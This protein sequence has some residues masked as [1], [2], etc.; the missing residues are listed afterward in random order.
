MMNHPAGLR[1]KIVPSPIGQINETSHNLVKE[2]W[3]E[4]GCLIARVEWN[5]GEVGNWLKPRSLEDFYS[6]SH[7]LEGD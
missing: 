1:A 2:L 4:K 6:R 7:H 3:D 5:T